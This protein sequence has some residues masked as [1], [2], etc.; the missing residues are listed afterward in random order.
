MNEKLIWDYLI[1][2]TKNPY[3]TSAI[4]GNLMAESS[5]NPR[6]MTGIKDPDYVS[7]ADAGDI[8]FAHDGHAFGLA[9]WCYYTRKGGL[10][11]YAKQTGRSVGDIQMQL[12]YLV[13]EM[14]QDYKSVWKAVTE[15]NAI[16]TTSDIVM[17]RYEKPGTMTEAAKVKRANFAMAFYNQFA[18]KTPTPEPSGKKTVKAKSQVNIRSGPGKEYLILGELKGN[19]TAELISTENGWHKIA[20]YVKAEYTDVIG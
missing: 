20:V 11:A 1:K 8:D 6:C 12:E 13:K 17:L 16:R 18:D 4:M 7:K 3:G 15:A 2:A 5:L 9:Q 10:Q 14:S 19:R